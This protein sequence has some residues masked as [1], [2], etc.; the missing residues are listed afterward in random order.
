MKTVR[1][2][3]PVVLLVLA[4]AA[5]AQSDAQKS[6]DQMK[7]LAGTWKGHVTAVPANPMSTARPSGS[8]C[9]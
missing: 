9:A 2:A 1:V 8:H 6:F 3:L 4:T 5:L 7:T